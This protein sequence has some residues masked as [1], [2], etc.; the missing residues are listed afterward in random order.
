MRAVSSL[1]GAR[2]IRAVYGEGRRARCDGIVAH[3]ARRPG[4][5]TRVALAVPSSV[6]GAVVRNRIRRRVR[7]A[8]ALSAPAE[9]HVVLRPEASAF[10][11]PFQELV[12]NVE[13]A[14]ARAMKA[15]G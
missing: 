8:F 7:A 15:A 9:V 3:V 1:S 6:G 14:V 4:R 13:G 10:S 11:M 5:T 12:S 2:D